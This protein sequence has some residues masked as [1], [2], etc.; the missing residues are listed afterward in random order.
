MNRRNIN[1]T[2]AVSLPNH[3]TSSRLRNQKRPNQVDIQNLLQ[4]FERIVHEREFFLHSRIVDDN[5]ELAE[6]LHG[7]IDQILDL[8]GLRDVGCY[9]D[10]LPTEVSDLLLSLARHIR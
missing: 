8:V 7:A 3:L 2:A 6:G 1:Q 4:L 5:V 10:T 9:C